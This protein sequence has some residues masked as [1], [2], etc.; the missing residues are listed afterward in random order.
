[1]RKNVVIVCSVS[2]ILLQTGC[3]TRRAHL[4]NFESGEVI[5]A[6]FTDTPFTNGKITV[7]MP[8]GEVLKGEYSAIRGQDSI[9][10]SSAF[11]S[12]ST[13][14][15]TRTKYAGQAEG[16]LG[17]VPFSTESSGQIN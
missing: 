12:G 4:A 2:L 7:A 15:N 8:D 16:R 9:T 10:F 11:V 13:D 14:I 1:M 5:R 6:K 17:D 3:V